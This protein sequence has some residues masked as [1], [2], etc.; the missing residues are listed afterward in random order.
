MLDKKGL[1][2]LRAIAQG[3]GVSDIFSKNINILKQD[4]L[5][6]SDKLI[7]APADVVI[8]EYKTIPAGDS[9]D[10]DVLLDLIKPYIKRGLKVSFTEETWRFSFGNKHDSGTLSMPYKVAI[11]KAQEVLA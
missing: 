5:L 7:P 2:E 10:K 9:I 8:V 4:I 6:K 11:K 1:P 3:L